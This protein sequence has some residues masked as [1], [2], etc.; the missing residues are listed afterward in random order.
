[1]NFRQENSDTLKWKK[2]KVVHAV[3]HYMY[4]RSS[5]YNKQAIVPNSLHQKKVYTCGKAKY[6]KSRGLEEM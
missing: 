1:M 3:H 2:V 6:S 4:F 5:E